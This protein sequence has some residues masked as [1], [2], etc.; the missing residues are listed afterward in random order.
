ML[1]VASSAG[2]QAGETS[3]GD[4]KY[5]ESNLVDLFND[6]ESPMPYS[7]QRVPHTK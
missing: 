4:D 6:G 1:D 7:C 2:S 3:D 5:F